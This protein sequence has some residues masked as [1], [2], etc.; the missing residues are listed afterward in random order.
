MK[1]DFETVEL[2]V[3]NG[4]DVTIVGRLIAS[5]DSRDHVPER[6]HN[7]DRW[8]VLQVYEL[9]DGAWVAVQRSISERRGESTYA[10]A[11]PVPKRPSR[12]A[13]A[14]D[15]MAA[16]G[17]GWLAKRLAADQGWNIRETYE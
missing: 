14:R 13:M 9:A 5:I 10:E 1:Q 7:R 4:P 3:K 6:E 17:W 11:S 15:V 16:F 8:T 12:D 2:T